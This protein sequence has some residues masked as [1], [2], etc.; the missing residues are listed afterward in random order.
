MD[1]V[2]TDAYIKTYW[3]R[4]YPVFERRTDESTRRFVN[5]GEDGKTLRVP[6]FLMSLD[7]RAIRA[8]LD[9]YYKVA[10]GKEKYPRAAMF[11]AIIWRILIKENSLL[12]FHRL[13]LDDPFGALEVGFRYDKD[14]AHV[15]VPS[16][17]ALWHFANVRLNVEGLETLFDAVIRENAKLA[18]ANGLSVGE[19]TGTDST[20]LETCRNDSAGT[21]NGHYKKKMVKVVITE[22][23]DTW[24]LLACK[25]IGGTDGDGE[26]LMEML[27][28]AKERVGD[29]VMKETWF[30]GGFTGNENLAKV[31]VLLGLEARYKISDGWVEE[32]RYPR[33]GPG[34][35]TPEEE[36]ERLYEECWKEGWYRSDA[37]LEYKMRC[38]VQAGE[39]EAVAMHF[40][41]AY[42]ARSNREPKAVLDEYHQ[43]NN[44]EGVNGHVKEH[45]ALE[46]GLNVVGT[47]AITRHVLWTLIAEHVV[48][49]V[50]LQHGVTGNLLSTT[51]I[52]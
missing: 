25:V 51:H 28:K 31:P 38:L 10:P 50:R 36:I 39:Y 48:A 9:R 6:E 46:V 5:P 13:L 18:K 52:Q 15:L 41:N 34:T 42:I 44:C 8:V 37:S 7:D 33:G 49:M 3:D 20:P 12:A 4:F 21:W 29:G 22:D 26:H 32:V 30:D 16:Y 43:R 19:R 14:T 24:L 45:Y 17:Q 11:R 40:R 23:L 35:R 47:R 1:E 27:G 2:Y